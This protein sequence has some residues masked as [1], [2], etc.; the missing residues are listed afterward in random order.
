MKASEMLDRIDREFSLL[1]KHDDVSVRFYDAGLQVDFKGIAFYK[2]TQ[3]ILFRDTDME[4]AYNEEKRTF[5]M[6][7]KPMMTL[8]KFIQMLR[9]MSSI[10]S[11]LK[12]VEC[13]SQY[14]CQFI[15]GVLNEDDGK[16]CT[17]VIS[18][19]MDD[20]NPEVV[21][22]L[23]ERHLIQQGDAT[24]NAAYELACAIAGKHLDWNQAYIGEIVD[25]AENTLTN[26]GIDTCRPWLDG[27]YEVP[28]Y[29]T[30]DC[31][32]SNCPLKKRG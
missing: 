26:L 3:L 19:D 16:L 11:D 31:A 6:V 12:I 14:V 22:T 20:E 29:L 2:D 13:Y 8:D 10:G 5:D 4:A 24:D 30:D 17:I 9:A 23:F 1:V 28:C 21:D 18:L 7:H 27:E 25:D 15:D 32:N